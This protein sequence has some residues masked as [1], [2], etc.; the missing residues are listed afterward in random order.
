MNKQFS[1]LSAWET[2]DGPSRRAILITNEIDKN[3]LSW[4][5]VG[6]MALF[7]VVVSVIAGLVVDSSFGV[8][9]C[10]GLFNFFSFVQ[11]CIVVIYK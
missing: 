9:T 6:V 7:A 4:G 10:T 11:G 3:I 5:V 2:A 8:A 1:V